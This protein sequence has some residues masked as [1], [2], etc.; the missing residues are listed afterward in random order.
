MEELMKSPLAALALAS[1]QADPTLKTETPVYT[2]KLY[3][4]MRENQI[5]LPQL[6]CA[7]TNLL[8]TYCDDSMMNFPGSDTI[9]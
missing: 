1:V 4:W 7:F 5:T 2:Q 9:N 3:E 8:G 6:I